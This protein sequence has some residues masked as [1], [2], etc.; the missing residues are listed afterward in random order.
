MLIIKYFCEGACYHLN[1]W[2]SVENDVVQVLL[3]SV[4]KLRQQFRGGRGHQNADGK[5]GGI[6]E[7]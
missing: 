7:W 6:L 5:G 4:H 2:Q 1:R 3:G